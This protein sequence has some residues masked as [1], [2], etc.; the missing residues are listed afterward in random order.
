MAPTGSSD[1]AQDRDSGLPLNFQ[2]QTGDLDQLIKGGSIRALVVYS[3]SGFFYVDGLPEG[4]FFRWFMRSE[5]EVCFR[6]ISIWAES[7]GELEAFEYRRKTWRATGSDIT[8][9]H[10]AQTNLGHSSNVLVI[11]SDQ[12]KR[13][14]N[15]TLIIIIVVIL[16]L[17]GG[18]WYGRGRWY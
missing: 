3:R 17:G 8:A 11:P 15:E 12:E 2:R 5:W 16:L 10:L 14:S 1:T 13:M 6:K 4:M 9:S 7:S 18:G